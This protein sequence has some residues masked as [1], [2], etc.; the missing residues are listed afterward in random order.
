MGG[1]A[2][3][4]V[5]ALSLFA[6]GLNPMNRRDIAK[7][8]QRSEAASNLLKLLANQT[9]L[10]I[11]CQL[12][13]GEKPVNELEES[14]HLGQSAISQHLA[15]LRRERVVKARREARHIYYSLASPEAAEL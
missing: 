10:Q 1:G 5:A 8:Q 11:L 4:R 13:D 2:G 12:L 15:I 9:R 3:P 14:L 7:L 6:A